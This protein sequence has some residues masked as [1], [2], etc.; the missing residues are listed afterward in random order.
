LYELKDENTDYIYLTF[1]TKNKNI[2][3]GYYRIKYTIYATAKTPD[4]IEARNASSIEE[5]ERSKSVN[6]IRV[7]NLKTI[8]R[9]IVDVFNKVSNRNI[10]SGVVYFIKS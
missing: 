1:E 8:Y 10:Y 5:L 6:T 3:A 4:W 7:L 2:P 9:D